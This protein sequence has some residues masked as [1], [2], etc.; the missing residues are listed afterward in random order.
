M[1]R[2]M[3]AADVLAC[4]M[5]DND[6]GVDTIRGYLAALLA[7]LWRW[8]DGFSSKRPFGNSG[9]EHDLYGALAKQG[10]ITGKFDEDGYLEEVDEDAG[11]RLIKA[12]IAWIASTEDGAS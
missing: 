8:G 5:D 12:A 3:S 4:P 1:V 2:N 10:Y 7:E 9:W 6:A 11:N